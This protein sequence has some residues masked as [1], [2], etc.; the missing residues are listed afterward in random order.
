MGA[1][2]GLTQT[3]GTAVPAKDYADPSASVICNRVVSRVRPGNVMLMHDGTGANTDDALR[4]IIKELRAQGYG[5]G[6]L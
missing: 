4:C 1:S 2:L 5:F 3:R 6:K